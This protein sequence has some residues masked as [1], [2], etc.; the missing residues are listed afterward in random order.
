[1][2]SG[3]ALKEIENTLL[4][5]FHDALLEGLSIDFAARSATMDIELWVGSLESSAEA[6]REARRKARLSLDDIIYLVIDPP[7]SKYLSLEKGSLWIDGGIHHEE[8]SPSL[9]VPMECLPNDAFTRW[10]FV[11]DWNSFIYLA[12]RGA[13]FEWLSG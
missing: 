9:P 13:T 4:N 11:K 8:R 5:G 12:A 3:D 7:D 1:M 2:D 10:F 6:E